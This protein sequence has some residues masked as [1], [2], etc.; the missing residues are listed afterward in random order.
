MHVAQE[1]ART[2]ASSSWVGD[3]SGTWTGIMGFE[4]TLRVFSWNLLSV[5]YRHVGSQHDHARARLD[6][7]ASLRA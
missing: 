5:I 2:S 4:Q 7:T 3:V 1:N 6:L